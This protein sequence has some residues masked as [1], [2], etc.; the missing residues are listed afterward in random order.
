LVDLLLK[1]LLCISELLGV[2][3]HE[4]RLVV[5]RGN[6]DVAFLQGLNLLVLIGERELLVIS[7]VLSMDFL[8]KIQ[9]A[10]VVLGLEDNRV[11][12]VVEKLRPDFL[13]Q[14]L[15]LRKILCENLLHENCASQSVSRRIDLV[16]VEILF[17]HGK[18]QDCL[19]PIVEILDNV[20]YCLLFEENLELPGVHL[21]DQSARALEHLHL[22]FSENLRIALHGVQ[23]YLLVSY[24]QGN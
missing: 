11:A 15:N 13:G 8:K 3:L 24:L 17:D 1:N 22:Y 7:Q 4:D 19:G 10:F 9:V 5:H 23:L 14:F 12:L 16:L 21:G 20:S 18:Q 6:E 2:V